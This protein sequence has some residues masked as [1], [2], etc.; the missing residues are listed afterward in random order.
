M[1]YSVP[2]RRPN[3]GRQFSDGRAEN[4]PTYCTSRSSGRSSAENI[5]D[6]MWQM[7]HQQSRVSQNKMN[8]YAESYP[9]RP[10]EADCAHYMRTGLC[11]FGMNCR[12]NHPMHIKQASRNTGEL[13]E[14]VG[15]NEC[16]FYLK[17]GTCKF[18]A[19]CKYH[20]PRDKAGSG[21]Q[22]QLN[23]LGLPMRMGEK[24]C[25]YY[26]RTGTC[27]YGV[28]CKY[29]HPQPAP[30]GTL[31]P[32]S[33]SSMYATAGPPLAP[34]SATTYSPGLSSWHSP[35]NPYASGP[36]IQPPPPYVPVIYS[37]SQGMLSAP[38]WGS[39]QGLASPLTSPERRQQ[40][41]GTG[42][43]Y[44][45]AQSNGLSA[46]GVRGVFSPFVQGSPVAMGLQG[47]Q[48]HIT[49]SQRETYPERPG[50]PECQYYMKTGDCKFGA[51][52]RYHHPYE[53]VSD[54]PTCTLSPIG[55]P[56]RP[57]QPAC[58]FYSRYGICKFGPTCKFDHPLRGLSYSPSA[59]SLSEL[60]VAPYPRGGSPT[61]TLVRSTSS[62]TSQ[63]IVKARDQL[64][65]SV[66][67]S[68][69]KQDSTTENPGNT[70]TT[71]NAADSSDATIAQ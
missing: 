37:P 30:V 33:G 17:T 26:M 8:G 71:E 6:S 62:E 54:S 36:R 39:Y 1:E 25:T 69:F 46:G 48:S 7:T 66:E 24:E 49:L 14:R 65:R 12:F 28:S 42:L 52:C 13:P 51:A 43:M 45:S 32:V 68:T 11:G 9:E 35:R 57:H 23:I 44:G 29:D 50:Q 38:G 5:Q 64:S 16:Q 15:Q 31:M 40:H 56:L 19:T 53:R 59:S 41:R 60:P 22:A 4:W 21:A 10:G 63:D 70:E 58:T 18:G 47:M 55:L 2:R 27:K 61:T 67:S 20:H 34:A 3:Q